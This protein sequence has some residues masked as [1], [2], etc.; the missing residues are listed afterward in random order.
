[1]VYLNLVTAFY[2]TISTYVN[3]HD[4]DSC[5]QKRKCQTVSVEVSKSQH[6]YVVGPR[7][8]HIQE[9]LA[10]FDVAVEVPDPNSPSETI[11]LRGEQTRLGMALT[12]VYGHVRLVLFC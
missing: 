6:K 10:K 3:M 9:I 2:T 5:S 11:T 1:M 12:E 7:Y 8:C 4:L